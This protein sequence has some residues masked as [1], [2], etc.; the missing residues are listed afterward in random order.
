[1]I[2]YQ[3]I[4]RFE[5]KVLSANINTVTLV[6]YCDTYMPSMAI[7]VLISPI[8]LQYSYI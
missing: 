8:I 4:L 3:S 1:M 7:Y 2:F 5:L 6:I